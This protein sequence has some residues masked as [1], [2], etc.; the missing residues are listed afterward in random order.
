MIW[1]SAYWKEDLLRL[2]RDL[3]RRKN[4]KHWSER[5]SALLEKTVMLGFYAIRKLIE[6]HKIS[7]EIVERPLALVA[8][9]WLGK[10]V[11]FMN[12][13][14]FQEKYDF[15]NPREIEKSLRF[16]CNQ[17]VHSYVFAQFLQENGGLDAV[18]FNSDR[19]RHE[20][21]FKIPVASLISL[22]AEIGTNDPSS[23][24]MV[25][26][27]RSGDYGVWVGLTMADPEGA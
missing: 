7:T 26:D 19:T 13:H 2:A 5:S 8:F 9:P 21:L 4:Q 17:L 3:E 11:T 23:I 10:P 1:E 14:R 25:L 18:V 16:L 15:Q 20:S 24:A 12:W 22:F 27:P 6:A